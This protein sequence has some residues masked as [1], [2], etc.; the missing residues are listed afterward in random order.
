LLKHPEQRNETDE[1]LEQKYYQLSFEIERKKAQKCEGT[2]TEEIN[3]LNRKET[4]LEMIPS[5]AINTMSG[6]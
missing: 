3:C 2:E 1:Q 4:K 5:F 6:L